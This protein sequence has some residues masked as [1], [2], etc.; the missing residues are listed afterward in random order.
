MGA[1]PRGL[2]PPVRVA[3]L[4]RGADRG[5]DRAT[6]AGRE[7]VECGSKNLNG[8]TEGMSPR[9]SCPAARIRG[10][11]A[12]RQWGDERRSWPRDGRRPIRLTTHPACGLSSRPSRARDRPPATSRWSIARGPRRG[13]SPRNG[14]GARR[15][16][17]GPPGRGSGAS[18]TADTPGTVLG[19]RRVGRANSARI[20]EPCRPRSGACGRPPGRDRARTEHPQPGRKMSPGAGDAPEGGGCSTGSSG[21]AGSRRGPTRRARAPA[22]RPRCSCC[23]R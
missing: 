17:P 23:G 16:R 18:P 12:H 1:V 19:R 2:V 9:T 11:A 5:D 15:T 4:G 13:R 7:G 6:V 3:S 14:P 10:P 8:D 20:S 21:F 22:C